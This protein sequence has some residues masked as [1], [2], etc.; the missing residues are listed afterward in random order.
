MARLLLVAALLLS[1]CTSFELTRLRNDVDRTPGV[2]IGEGYAVAF[3]R[4]SVGTL[5]TGLRLG[6][7]ED[8]EAVRA[9]LGHVR[10]AQFGRYRVVS[11]PPLAEV[12][13]PRAVARYIRRGW[14]PALVARDDDAAVWLLARDG[15]D[16]LRDLLIVTLLPRELIVGKLSG[17]LTEAV[18]AFVATTRLAGLDDLLGSP[19]SDASAPEAGPSEAPSAQ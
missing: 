16:E 14:T 1:G 13:T 18:S 12:E 11:A 6:D 19:D 15:D 5:R 9:A 17:D 7:D 8:A 10:K 4:L 3:G 2:E